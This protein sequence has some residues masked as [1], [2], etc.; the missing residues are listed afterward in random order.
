MGLSSIFFQNIP[1]KTRPAKIF[2]TR[3]YFSTD[4]LRLKLLS[5]YYA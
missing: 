3:T 5:Q 1:A 4:R 2:L